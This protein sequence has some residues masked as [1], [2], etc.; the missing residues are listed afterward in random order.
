MLP[1]LFESDGK[2]PNQA[3]T[4]APAQSTTSAK[5]VKPIEENAITVK[6]KTALSKAIDNFPIMDAKAKEFD[7]AL[8]KIDKIE[9]DEDDQKAEA[10][11]VKAGKAYD[12]IE[13]K[14]KETTE[15]TDEI[16][17]SMMQPEKLISKLA[18]DKDSSY[19][20]V[21]G[22][23]NAWAN[24]KLQAQEA[25]K[26]EAERVKN[27]TFELNR[28]KTEFTTVFNNKIVDYLANTEVALLTHFNSLNLEK[29]DEQVK[30]FNLTPAL[31]IETF[32]SW[33]NLPFNPNFLTTEKYNEF[34]NGVKGVEGEEDVKGVKDVYT[35]EVINKIYVDQA[36]PKIDEYK[37]KLPAKKKELEDLAKLAETDKKA[38]DKLVKEN[39]E[40]AA[41]ASALITSNAT[42]KKEEIS[43]TAAKEQAGNNLNA[44]FEEL[45]VTQNLEEI[46]GSKKRKAIIN[47]DPK[48]IVEVL[49]NMLFLCF[50]NPKFEGYLDTDKEGNILPADENGIPQYA[51]WLKPIVKF[52]EE[53]TSNDIAGVYFKNVVSTVQGGKGRKKADVEDL[54]AE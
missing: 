28:L 34:L 40:K 12:L 20:K 8:K 18:A 4:N 26:K 9:N 23:R 54:T 49:A 7:E 31:K 16:K 53:H 25:K 22:L 47:C 30:K 19:N 15:L 2:T 1:S 27:E 11:L 5:E 38:A 45:K 50:S 14:R 44:Q 36:Q 51:K 13:A 32:N 42:A 37:K 43:A 35:Y 29:W 41:T 48:D 3:Q 21:K 39:A 17:K 24:K 10:L 33:F 6:L 46:G 52:V